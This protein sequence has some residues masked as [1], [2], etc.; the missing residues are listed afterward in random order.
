[1]YEN[2]GN[3][4]RRGGYNKRP[5]S[6]QSQGGERGNRGNFGRDGGDRGNRGQGGGGRGGAA[7]GGNSNRGYDNSK[8]YKNYSDSRNQASEETSHDIGITNKFGNLEVDV[9]EAE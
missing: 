3:A 9:G 8:P 1:M 4:E 5:D 6:H 7:R 2:R